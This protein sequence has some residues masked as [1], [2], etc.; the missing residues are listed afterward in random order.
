MPSPAQGFAGGH[1]VW[2]G[3]AILVCSTL[4]SCP[5]KNSELHGMSRHATPAEAN[6]RILES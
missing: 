5:P 1:V 2:L 6:M 4:L 3:I